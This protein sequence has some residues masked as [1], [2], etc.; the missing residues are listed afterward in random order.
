MFVIFF[1]RKFGKL[2]PR[3][4]IFFFQENSASHLREKI[5]HHGAF[6]R[7]LEV[8]IVENDKRRFPAKFLEPI[9]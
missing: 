1:A 9:L 5:G 8:G 2:A 6:D 7:V 4:R 3:V